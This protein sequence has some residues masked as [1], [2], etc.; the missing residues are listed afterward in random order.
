[1]HAWVHIYACVY[2]HINIY[3]YEYLCVWVCID[4]CT[5]CYSCFFYI[6]ILF[7]QMVVWTLSSKLPVLQQHWCSPSWLLN[8]LHTHLL[9][10][11]RCCWISSKTFWNDWTVLHP[12]SVAVYYY[13]YCCLYCCSSRTTV[14]YYLDMLPQR[15][16]FQN[17]LK[18]KT[19]LIIFYF[20]TLLL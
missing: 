11:W 17:H 7:I 19:L 13:S 15:S 4:T 5:N 3:I 12:M 14:L 6:F 20:I 8:T 16:W 1:M 2:I 9:C 18:S 10:C